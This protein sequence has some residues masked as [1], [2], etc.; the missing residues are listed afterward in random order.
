MLRWHI[1]IQV[2]IG[3]HRGVYCYLKNDNFTS[4]Q[5]CPLKEMIV[6]YFTPIGMTICYTK[7]LLKCSIRLSVKFDSVLKQREFLHYQN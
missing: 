5:F 6:C 4:V 2:C 3:V 7:R 1:C